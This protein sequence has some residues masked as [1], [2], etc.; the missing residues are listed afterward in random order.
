MRFIKRLIFVIFLLVAAFFVYRLI[1]PTA[2]KELLYDLKS[3]A[4]DKI[5]THFYLSGEVEVITWTVLDETGIILEETWA[6]QE[7]TG[8]EELLLD[9][10]VV[11][12]EDFAAETTTT[13]T[14]TA[15][16][17]TT[18]TTTTTPK[19]TTTSSN[20]LSTQD[21]TDLKNLLKN[22]WN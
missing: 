3:F 22:F 10:A 20:G 17:T 19:T 14:T 8:D 12:Q 6:L 7:I 2:A 4:N 18:T 11:T 1:K 15:P 13:T 16:N 21:M 9:D 5:G